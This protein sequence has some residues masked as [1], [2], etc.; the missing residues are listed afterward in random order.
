M[1]RSKKRWN[2][3]RYR[4]GDAQYNRFRGVNESQAEREGGSIGDPEKQGEEQNFNEGPGFFAAGNGKIGEERLLS[5]E[6][7]GF[8]KFIDD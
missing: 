2:Q 5:R 7:E 1:D 8:F 6:G 3:T 4:A